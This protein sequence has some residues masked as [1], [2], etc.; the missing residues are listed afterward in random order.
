MAIVN[1]D[2]YHPRPV[3]GVKISDQV[4]DLR[5]NSDNI[6]PLVVAS[7]QDYDSGTGNRVLSGLRF[8]DLVKSNRFQV[9][10][11]PTG[12]KFRFQLNTGTETSPVWED[13]IL[14][15]MTDKSVTIGSGGLYSNG[16]FYNISHPPNPTVTDSVQS[17]T[18]PSQIKF[19]SNDFYL[20]NDGFGN[21]E[22]FLKNASIKT[23]TAEF[24]NAATVWEVTHNFNTTNPVIAQVYD[25]N[26]RFLI[27]D[28]IYSNDPNKVKFY[29]YTAQSGR[30]VIIGLI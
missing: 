3:L 29:F 13:I 17:F 10:Y 18:N 30:A 14:V 24:Q 16:S 26:N 6:Y 19:T 15:D 5:Y 11:D 21:P 12:D 2:F 4:D 28:E 22:V 27:P 9:K 8:G 7:E 25:L 23:L 1:G 20:Q